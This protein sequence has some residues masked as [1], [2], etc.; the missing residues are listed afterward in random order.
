MIHSS[1][2]INKASLCLPLSVCFFPP[3]ESYSVNI[4]SALIN[5]RLPAVRILQ[6][7]SRERET[8]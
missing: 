1:V 7:T 6:F 5:I 4:C 8:R 2:D 3:G